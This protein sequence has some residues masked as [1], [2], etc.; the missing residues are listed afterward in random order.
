M[1]QAVRIDFASHWEVKHSAKIA[2]SEFRFPFISLE[3]IFVWNWESLR[4]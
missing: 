2:S 3:T 1:R 4:A